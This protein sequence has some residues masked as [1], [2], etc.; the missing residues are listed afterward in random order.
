MTVKIM[1]FAIEAH[2]KVNQTYDGKPYSVHLCM[3]YS[4][5]I[6]FINHIPPHR[7]DDVLNAV[8]LHDTIEDC[9]LTYNDI[10][11]I[12][13]K[14]VAD[15]VYAVTNE[16]GKNRKERANEKYY[17]G[18]RETEFATF[19]K[20]CDRLAN[21]LYSK[22]TDSRMFHVYRNENEE[23]LKHLFERPDQQLRYREL[24]QALKD[25]FPAE[26][27]VLGSRSVFDKM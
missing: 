19:I 23:F 7:R 6:G 2:D 10:L 18:I 1:A 14:E 25:A 17:K 11:K 22:A 5:A 27:S 21:V 15:L 8:W 13:N 24:V 26:P 16:K 3:V 9:R 20:I 4:V 12:S